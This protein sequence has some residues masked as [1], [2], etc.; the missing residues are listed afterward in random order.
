VARPAPAV[1]LIGDVRVGANPDHQLSRLADL[2]V[3][4]TAE[5]ER[6]RSLEER[7]ARQTEWLDANRDHPGY[8]ERAQHAWDVRKEHERIM[9][10]VHDIA[11]DANRLNEQMDPATKARAR[12]EIHEWSVIGSPGVYGIAWDIEPDKAW[13]EELEEQTWSNDS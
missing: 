2:W 5:G 4:A 13:F 11:K 3:E 12:G 10:R 1:L 8:S 9:R 6:L 7:I